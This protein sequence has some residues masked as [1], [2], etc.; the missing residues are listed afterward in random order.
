M[1]SHPFIDEF[2]GIESVRDRNH[3]INSYKPNTIKMYDEDDESKIVVD[4]SL[5][6]LDDV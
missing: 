6:I 2:I 5:D 3:R 4:N 1:G